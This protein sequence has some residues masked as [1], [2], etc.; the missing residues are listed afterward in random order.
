MR[1]DAMKPLETVRWREG[2]VRILDQ[3]LLPGDEVYRDLATVDEVCTAIRTLAVRG[4]RQ[5]HGYGQTTCVIG[6]GHDLR[7]AG[8]PVKALLQRSVGG[9]EGSS[10]LP[11]RFDIE[12]FIPSTLR[13]QNNFA[14]LV[15][16][17]DL[18]LRGTY[19]RP[20]VFGHAEVNRGEVGI[21]DNRHF[22]FLD[23]K[24]D[25]RVAVGPGG[26]GSGSRRQ[27]L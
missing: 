24:R 9:G 20:Q 27:E 17:A 13:V 14:R 25:V 8:K 6:R 22:I 11:M 15:A 2:K 21:D 12:L 19:D 10:T 4:G 7:A 26:I 1:A 16:S 23:A 5:F 3:T 18:Q